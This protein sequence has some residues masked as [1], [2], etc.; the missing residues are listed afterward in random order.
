[1]YHNP[2]PSI[3][4]FIKSQQACQRTSLTDEIDDYLNNIFQQN[5][6]C[7][8]EIRNFHRDTER[9]RV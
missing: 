5:L 9:Y 3:K 2:G 4:C 7:K 8:I 1:M 6:R